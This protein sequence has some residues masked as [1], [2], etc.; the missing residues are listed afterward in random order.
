MIISRTPYRMSFFGGGTDYP[1]WFEKHEGA[2]LSATIDKYCYLTV[3]HLPP[4]FEHKSRVVWRMVEQVQ[5]NN[6]IQHPA[7]RAALQQM[8]IETGIEIHHDGDLPSRSGL[9]SSSSFTVGLYNALY[10]LQGKIISK[11]DLAKI[12]IYTEKELLKEEV[13][14]Q[15]Q[16]AA[17]YGGLNVIKMHPNHTFTVEPMIVS[18]QRMDEFQSSLMLFYT[19]ISRTAS[20]VAKHK[21]ESFEAKKNNLHTMHQMVFEAVKILQS[22]NQPIDELGRL[23]H[24]SWLLKRDISSKIA[25]DFVDDIYAR[26][27]QAGAIGGKLLGAGGGGF[28]LFI[29]EPEKQYE[30]MKTLHE[31]LYVPVK[32]DF[33]GSQI[34]FYHHDR[35]TR[36][37]IGS[38]QDRFTRYGEENMET[39][40]AKK[41]RIGL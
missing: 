13:G 29:V 31:L 26:G 4:F 36:T 30:V 1:K 24:E 10:A 15:D 28:M 38:E 32:F 23:L 33:S 19:G 21:V 18:P 22:S 6:D 40:E 41:Q 2:V 25:P 9:G 12:A 7:V 11:Y 5:N 20:D 3:R 14:V 39:N 37:A 17:A 34:I 27:R 16:I 35:Y 8:G